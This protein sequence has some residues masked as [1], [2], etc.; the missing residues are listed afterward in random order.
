VR[1]EKNKQEESWLLLQQ[2]AERMEEEVTQARAHV[3]LYR[4]E[5]QEAID[6]RDS[7]REQLAR[8]RDSTHVAD[9][10]NSQREELDQKHEEAMNKMEQLHTHAMEHNRLEME[11]LAED[12][13]LI[14]NQEKNLHEKHVQELTLRHESDVARLREEA[15]KTKD[16]MRMDRQR[17][18]EEEAARMDEKNTEIKHLHS[19]LETQ[20]NKADHQLKE[21]ETARV[22]L[23]SCKVELGFR[24]DQ[25]DQVRRASGTL[26]NIL[27]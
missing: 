7:L 12:R 25:V 10:L 14:L 15:M 27:A 2:K 24:T 26:Y 20:R 8:A 9:Q 1:E 13:K 11:K 5:T 3:E 18:R 6:E 22:D 17:E 21:A 16:E 4:M 23:E 19:Q